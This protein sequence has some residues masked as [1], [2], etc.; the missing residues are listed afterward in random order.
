M[1]KLFNVG[2]AAALLASCAP[3]LPKDQYQLDGNIQG[4]DNQS[5]YMMYAVD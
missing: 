1:K 2:I 3:Q 5:S 4:V